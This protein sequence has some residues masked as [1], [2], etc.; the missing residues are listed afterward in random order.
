MYVLMVMTGAVCMCSRHVFLAVSV[1][2]LPTFVCA[3]ATNVH[4]RLWVL[5]IV[6]SMH[7]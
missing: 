2:F 5:S 6:C 1:L 4:Y 7:A 3:C